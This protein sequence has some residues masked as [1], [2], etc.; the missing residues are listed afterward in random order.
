M[1]IMG[2]ITIIT[3]IIGAIHTTVGDTAHTIIRIITFGMVRVTLITEC[4]PAISAEG[5]IT[6]STGTII[7]EIP[8]GITTKAFMATTG[9]AV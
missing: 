2:G 8:T 6:I 7:M 9:I 4:H 5:I 1:V 3:V